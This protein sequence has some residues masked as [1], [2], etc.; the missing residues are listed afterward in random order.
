M[1]T[2]SHG[3]TGGTEWGAQ[4]AAHRPGGRQDPLSP[5]HWGPGVAA[6]QCALPT[7]P[8]GLE[9]AHNAEEESGISQG[10][11]NLP[12]AL[13]CQGRA[14]QAAGAAMS[15]RHGCRNSHLL[16]WHGT[17]AEVAAPGSVSHTSSQAAAEE[18][19]GQST[20]REPA[21]AAGRRGT[22]S[23][24][25]N[26]E[27][28]SAAGA[29]LLKHGA[30]KSPTPAHREEAAT[31]P[32]PSPHARSARD[33][34]HPGASPWSWAGGALPHPTAAGYEAEEVSGSKTPNPVGSVN[35]PL[36]VDPRPISWLILWGTEQ[37]PVPQQQQ[38]AAS[39]HLSCSCQ[40][41]SCWQ[42]PWP[43][44]VLCDTRG[45]MPGDIPQPSMGLCGTRALRKG[46]T[47][48]ECPGEA[49]PTCSWGHSCLSL[50]EQ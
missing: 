43:V 8:P 7:A 12:A 31:F 28:P 33:K 30:E 22:A 24:K 19:G 42:L 23:G 49:S 6:P 11:I 35:S 16:S 32:T 41:R 3:H 44:P 25:H 10:D 5:T 1:G 27:S 26:R 36:P 37:P 15:P 4:R 39:P 2:A 38:Q 48:S 20:Q 45:H 34:W 17:P 13:S 46:N 40:D 47:L 18:A 21:P 29:Q 50:G 9:G 14:P